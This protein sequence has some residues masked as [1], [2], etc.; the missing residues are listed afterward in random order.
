MK[1]VSLTLLVITATLAIPPS[2]FSDSFGYTASG[3]DTSFESN[4]AR[5]LYGVAHDGAFAGSEMPGT[6]AVINETPGSFGA[7]GREGV[8]SGFGQG[9]RTQSLNG[10]FSFD[11]LLSPGNSGD[12]GGAL[13]DISGEE[14]SLLS[15]GSG[16]GGGPG[17]GHF[18]FAD[19]GSYHVGNEAPKNNI[20][21]VAETRELTV[22]PEPG[23]LF[24]LGTGLLGLALGLFWKSAKRSTG[25]RAS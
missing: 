14:I 1:N 13:I 10:A 6:F 19:K 23:S 2:A 25:A 22:T 7:T 8:D 9:T 21:L 12:K 5:I 17:A 18:Y 4:H 20:N 3:S 24:L 15:G 16:T 11:N